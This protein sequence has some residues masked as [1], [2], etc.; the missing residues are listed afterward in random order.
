MKCIQKLLNFI[1][2]AWCCYI[3]IVQRIFKSSDMQHISLIP[4]EELNSL[5]YGMCFCVNIY[6]SY[7]L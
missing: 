6:G 1:V 5:M 4:D 2:L 7:K 3:E